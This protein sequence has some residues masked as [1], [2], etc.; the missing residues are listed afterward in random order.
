MVLPAV[1]INYKSSFRVYIQLTKLPL[2]FPARGA[3]REGGRGRG[4]REDFQGSR[5]TAIP[6]VYR[7]GSRRYG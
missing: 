6:A 4:E 3:E 5:R 1:I 2:L 7:P